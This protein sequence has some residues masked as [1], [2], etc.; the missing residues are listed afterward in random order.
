MYRKCLE[1]GGKTWSVIGRSQ[2]AQSKSVAADLTSS[3]VPP[4]LRVPVSIDKLRDSI[5]IRLTS[6]AESAPEE[7]L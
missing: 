4:G 5:R 2:V 1:M 6:Q 7:H 3:I